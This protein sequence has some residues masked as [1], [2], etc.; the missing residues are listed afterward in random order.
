VTLTDVSMR[1]VDGALSD[2]ITPTV[3]GSWSFTSTLFCGDYTLIVTP[4]DWWTPPPGWL[5]LYEPVAVVPGVGTQ[6]FD[7]EVV[8]LKAHRA[9]WWL[10]LMMRSGN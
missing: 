8:T 1:L 2:V 9:S 5:P 3:G 4:A 10:P 6:A 7:F